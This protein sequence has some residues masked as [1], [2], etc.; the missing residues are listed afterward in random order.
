MVALN[1]SGSAEGE[2]YMDDGSSFAFNRGAYVHRHF[3]HVDVVPNL[4][5][6]HS[7]VARMASVPHTFSHEG[8]CHNF[9]PGMR[10]AC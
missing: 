1:S 10:T 3:R 6:Q 2:L 4:C 7:D 8:A 5:R 9:R